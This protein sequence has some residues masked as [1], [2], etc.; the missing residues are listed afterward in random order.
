M[1]LQIQNQKYYHKNVR[2]ELEW[3]ISILPIRRRLS[4]SGRSHELHIQGP[5]FDSSV[6][7]TLKKFRAFVLAYYVHLLS[8]RGAEGIGNFD[9]LQVLFES[10]EGV[11][12]SGNV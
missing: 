4:G 10:K 2:S 1:L 5:A 9:W 3:L 12:D 7:W 6:L 11:C 8:V